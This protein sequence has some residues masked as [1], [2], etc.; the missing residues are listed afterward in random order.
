MKSTKNNIYTAA[1][2]RKD[3]LA[4]KLSFFLCI[5][6]LSLTFI[7]ALGLY[8][9]A[10]PVLALNGLKTV[11]FSSSWH[12]AQGQFGLASF[13]SGTLW[14][15]AIAMIIAIPLGLLTAIYLSWYTH[16]RVREAVR[17][18]IDVLAG[19]SP[20]IY[21]F[22]GVVAV[23]P[24]VRD[25]IMP[26]MSSHFK[27][28][29]FLS[30]NYTG[31]SALA[32]GMVLAVMVLPIIISIMEEVLCAVPSGMGEASLALG[33]TKWQTVKS[34]ILRQAWPGIIA[35]I[36]LGLSRA[37]GETMAVLMVSG[38]AL[39]VIPHSI[40]DPAYPLPAFIANTYGEMMSIP[41]Y[42]AAVLMAAFILLLVTALFNMVG[43]S[44]LLRIENE[45]S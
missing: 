25:H 32:G 42:D 1:R 27:F 10:R 29:P 33:A 45:M 4:E 20:V 44:I 18:I 40:F 24:L 28:F 30:D 12:P 31:F 11:L 38:C 5:G 39:G 15:T 34:V 35:A 36:I 13:I 41:I 8:F 26:F 43:W 2:N 37:F 23:V 7:M 16:R 21:G 17:P 3:A 19:I 9:K 6:I 22:W 14:V